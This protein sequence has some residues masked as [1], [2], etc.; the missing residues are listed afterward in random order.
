MA[1]QVLKKL[2]RY[3]IEY[4]SNLYTK[5][6]VCVAFLGVSSDSCQLR[7]KTGVERLTAD[8]QV[9]DLKRHN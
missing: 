5:L 3:N 8:Q 6:V 4:G 1:L 2:M 7:Y 9:I